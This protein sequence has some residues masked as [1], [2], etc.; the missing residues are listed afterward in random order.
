[1]EQLWRNWAAKQPEQPRNTQA[2]FLGFCQ[3]YVE[4]RDDSEHE[5]RNGPRPILGEAAHPDALW[6]WQRLPRARQEAAV[7]EFQICGRGTDWA[8]ARTDKQI[9]EA[10]AHL[11]G[12]I[13]RP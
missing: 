8:F 5:D 11:W 2:A 4:L 7:R 6:W 3:R 12:G 9:I 13:E 10:A 1:M